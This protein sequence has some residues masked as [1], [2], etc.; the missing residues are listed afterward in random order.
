MAKR[1]TLQK[2]IIFVVVHI[3]ITIVHVFKFTSI[4]V[5]F[6]CKCCKFIIKFRNCNN[7]YVYNICKCIKNIYKSVHCIGKTV[8][9]ISKFITFVNE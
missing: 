5:L 2:F 6:T 3:A 4:S 9:D 1:G 8:N 7:K